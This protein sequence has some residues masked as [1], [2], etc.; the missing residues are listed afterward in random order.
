MAPGSTAYGEL[1][2]FFSSLSFQ[3]QSPAL[4]R[5]RVT[6][7]PLF[8]DDKART[9]LGVFVV[10]VVP[11]RATLITET[12]DAEMRDINTLTVRND[13]SLQKTAA[14]G[15]DGVAGPAFNF[16]DL[17]DSTLN[18]RLQFG[19]AFRYLFSVSRTAG[20]GGSGRSSRPARSR[21]TSP[22]S[23]WSARRSTSSSA[24]APPRPGSSTRG[25]STG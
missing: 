17:A 18:L 4:S 19:G 1:N 21:A 20:L 24:A 7:V 13:R 6:T 5:G 14:V 10:D 22:A 23:T 16:F 11:G 9:P 3:R 12:A 15:I 25:A 2:S 8:A